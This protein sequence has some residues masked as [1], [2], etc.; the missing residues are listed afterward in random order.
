MSKS[1]L[2]SAPH[3]IAMPWPLGGVFYAAKPTEVTGYGVQVKGSDN[4]QFETLNTCEEPFR[5]TT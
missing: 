1:Q 4:D 3:G 5:R 2:P